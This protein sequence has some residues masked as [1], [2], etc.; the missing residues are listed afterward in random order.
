ME[1]ISTLPLCQYE[2]TSKTIDPIVYKIKTFYC[3]FGLIEYTHYLGGGN[4]GKIHCRKPVL[5]CWWSRHWL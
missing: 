4:N 2:K 1:N 5:R 3:S